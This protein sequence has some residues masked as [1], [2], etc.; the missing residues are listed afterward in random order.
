MKRPVEI[1]S[2]IGV[3]ATSLLTLMA[4]LKMVFDYK[5]KQAVPRVPVPSIASLVLIGVAVLLSFVGAFIL[6]SWA[7]KPK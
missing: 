1:A 7:N 6:L 4:L 5:D 3:F 2:G